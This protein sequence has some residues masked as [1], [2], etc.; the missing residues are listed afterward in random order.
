MVLIHRRS[1]ENVV[2]KMIEQ[3]VNAILNNI[4]R[5]QQQSKYDHIPQTIVVTKHQSFADI[6]RLYDLGFRHFGENRVDALLNRQKEFP[7]QDIVWHLIGTLQTRKVKQIVEYVDVIHA[8]DRLS[9]V[10]EIEKR[11]SSKMNCF[12]QVNIFEE[13]SKHGFRVNELP[14]AL[15]MISQQSK[16]NIIGLMTM[17]PNGASPDY[18]R[19]GFAKLKQLQEVIATQHI[20]NCPCFATSMGMS[21]DY[22]IAIQEG[23]T[24][25]RVGSAFFKK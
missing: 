25:I 1:L 12:L 15:K 17:A 4:N 23:A 9:L 3:N 24:H 7:Q 5:A 6:S 21:Q 20:L 16:I 8:L 11:A 18:I 14:D 19:Q 2:N 10:E 13:E 22:I